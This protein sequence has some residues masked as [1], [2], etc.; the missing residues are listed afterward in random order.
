MN[1]FSDAKMAS[2]HGSAEHPITTM[3]NS[4]DRYVPW[5]GEYAQGKIG[6][7]K[8]VFQAL[9]RVGDRSIDRVIYQSRDGNLHAFY[10]DVSAPL[11]ASRDELDRAWEEMKARG[12]VPPDLM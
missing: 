2:V 6:P 11:K 9:L 8:K 3:E 7:H 12:E 1:D 10:F 4:Q 5:Q